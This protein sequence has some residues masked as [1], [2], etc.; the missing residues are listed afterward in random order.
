MAKNSQFVTHIANR[1]EDFPQWYTDVIM[2]ADMVDYST[3]RGCVVIKPYGYAIWENIQKYLDERFKET[4]HSNA[5]FPLLIPES[6]L[7]KEVDHVEGFAPEVA[8]VTHAG[9]EEL[10]ERLCIRPT[11]ETVICSMFA[12]WLM[13]YR[14]LPYLYNQWANVVRWEKTTRPFLRTSEFLWQEGHTLHETHEEAEEET[15]RMLG[16]YVDLAEKIMAVPVI[17]GQK[18]E[19]ERFAGAAATYTMEA[20]MHDG[21]ALQMGTSHDLGQH[22]SK[23]YDI[24]FSGRDGVEQNPYQ[25]SWGVSTR[26]I[27]GLI[28]VHGDER[29]LKLPPN[30]APIQTVIIPIAAAKGGV[31]EKA[32]ELF[33]A[34]KKAGIKVKLDER[35]EVSPGYKFNEW[36][37]KGVPIRLEIGPR[38]I[39]NG[40]VAY[41]R[42]DNFT[43]G[44]IP[45]GEVAERIAEILEDIQEN[46]FNM[47]LEHRENHTVDALD[48]DTFTKH[49]ESNSGFVRAMWCEEGACEEAIKEKTGATTRCAPFKQHEISNVCVHCGKPAKK[50][51]YFAKAY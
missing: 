17:K 13:S 11:S 28:M 47:A 29:G 46:M 10:Q 26:L 43:K 42:R 27:G 44:E 24:E 3:V 21:K 9:G 48:F 37:L 33:E 12:K 4:G 38:D 14:D 19:K 32:E 35:S 5:Y 22:F 16:V 6:L 2:Q 34:L 31:M 1:E 8:W 41:A 36:E 40:V 39:E 30:I 23:V 49:I 20:L 51:M 7:Q 15:L 18:S 25:T 45:I 50:M